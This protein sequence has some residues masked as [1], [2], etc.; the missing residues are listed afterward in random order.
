[1]KKPTRAQ[2]E[3]QVDRLWAKIVVERD[4]AC[5][6]CNSEFVLQAHHIRGRQHTATTYDVNNGL[7]LCRKCHSLQKFRPEQFHDMIIDIIGQPEYDRLKAKSA[8]IVK[9][10]YQDLVEIKEKLKP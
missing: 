7:T 9:H 4:N 5:R 3:K 2:L 10:Y 1:M 8:A 6:N